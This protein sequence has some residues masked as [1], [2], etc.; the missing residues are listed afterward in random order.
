MSDRNRTTRTSLAEF[1]YATRPWRRKRRVVARLQATT[2]SFDAR[3][4]VA[5]LDG[6]PHRLCEWVY[7]E[8]GPRRMSSGHGTSQMSATHGCAM[9]F[10]DA[11]SARLPGR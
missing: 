8:R 7:C 3:Y 1:D 9:E 6:E 4:I 10:V 5:S 11:R 2:R